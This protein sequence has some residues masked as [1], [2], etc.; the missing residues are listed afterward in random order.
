MLCHG[1]ILLVGGHQIL[2]YDIVWPPSGYHL[3]DHDTLPVVR[4][5]LRYNTVFFAKPVPISGL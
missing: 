4:Y 1:T 5:H 3:R 2:G